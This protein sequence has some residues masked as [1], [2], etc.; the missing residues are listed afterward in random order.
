MP[1]ILRKAVWFVFAILGMGTSF[2]SCNTSQ[3]LSPDEKLLKQSRLDVR[4]EEKISDKTALIKELNK[5]I[6]QKPNTKLLFFIPKEWIYL[7]NS[8]PGKDKFFNRWA[9]SLGEPPLLYDSLTAEKTRIKIQNYLR[10]KKGFYDAEVSMDFKENNLISSFETTGNLALHVRQEAYLS[11]IV[12]LNK[13]FKVRSVNYLSRD[14][15]VLQMLEKFRD[16]SF[17]KPGS[18]ID[19]TQFELEKSRMVLEL[20]N[21]G[22]ANFANNYIEIKG[23]SNALT[24][25]VDIFFEVLRPLPDT[26]HQ[27]YT[28]GDITVYTDYQKDQENLQLDS[29]DIQG[30]TLLKQSEHY[31]V[32][33]SVLRSSVFLRSDLLLRREDRLKTF[34]KLNS[35]GTYR[36]VAMYPEVRKDVDSIMDF[37]ILLTPYPYKW[38]FD[39]GLE[40][41]FSTLGAA[42]LFGFSVN[43]A[44]QNRNFL[45]GSERFTVRGELG[46]ELGINRNTEGRLF[47]NQRARNFGIQTNLQLPSFLDFLG[48]GGLVS[49]T[50]L[51]RQRFYNAFRDETSTN[52]S[53]GYSSNT[54]IQFYSINS[55]NASFGFDYTAGS[56]NRYIFRP[57]GFNFDRY[58]IADSSRFQFNPLIFLQFR[59]VLG[60]GFLFRDFSFIYN[61]KKSPSG[62]SYA[63]VHNLEFSGVEMHLLNK[64]YNAVSGD[65]KEWKLKFSNREDDPGIAFA[66]Y[67]RYEMDARFNQEYSRTRSLAGRFNF[68]ILVP[69]D[70]N[71]V[72]PFIKQFGVGGPNSLRAW[73]IKEPGPGGYIDPLSKIRQRPVIFIQQGDLKLEANLEYRFNIFSLID[74]AVFADAGN[75]W[76]LKKDPDRPDAEIG[77]R[78]YEQIALAVGY[79]IRANFEFFIIRFD[80]GFK[81]RSPYKDPYTKRNW[82]TF[83]EIRQQGLGNIQVAVNYPF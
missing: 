71:S 18:P 12:N 29:E 68:G 79:G 30:L 83:E 50:G 33:P 39:G 63:M 78:F 37:T 43:S 60:T 48:M 7:K 6:D 34:R 21:H 67:F 24:K 54:I 56:G 3:F 10:N 70:R 19:F 69:Y 9:R 44:F 25:E 58:N 80:A 64:L 41:Y 15:A 66:K 16:E 57:L 62:R 52:I 65:D 4:S 73:N 13:R 49:R 32:K 23:D 26:L 5:L 55:I 17:I 28:V 59:D 45:G 47:F 14:T 53:L 20:Q 27:R 74:G 81:I 61:G 38:V 1:G 11:Y 8:G 77:S 35:L 51:I 2:T 31:L 40:G 22:F 72:A 36:F 42:R 76:N 75:V 82:Y 46:V